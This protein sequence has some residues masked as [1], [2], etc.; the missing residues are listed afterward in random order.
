MTECI[1]TEKNCCQQIKHPTTI[2]A[3]RK[4]YRYTIISAWQQKVLGILDTNSASIIDLLVFILR[5]KLPDHEHQ[6]NALR[7]RTNDIMDLWSEQLPNES[8]DWAVTAATETYRGEVED[9]IQPNRGFHFKATHAN[10][11]QLKSF[12]MGDM[13]KKIKTVAPN[14]WTLLG[15]LLDARSISRRRAKPKVGHSTQPNEDVE[16]SFEGIGGTEEEWADLDGDEEDESD[17]SESENEVVEVLP[18]QPDLAESSGD[19]GSDRG[20]P[21]AKKRKRRRKQNPGGML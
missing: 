7:L 14:L 2:S 16:M 8:R 6:R 18:M 20:E 9:L 12:S 1:R 4:P 11:E 13:G 10:L 17:A 15:V 21:K 19:D 3:N 5:T